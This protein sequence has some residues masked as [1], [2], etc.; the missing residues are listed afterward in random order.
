MQMKN[1]VLWEKE[2]EKKINDWKKKKNFGIENLEKL[3]T[4]HFDLPVHF[5]AKECS[6]STVFRL[7]L[8]IA[9]AQKR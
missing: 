3:S 5:F 2:K 4:F 9:K 8:V 6:P 1:L 7:A